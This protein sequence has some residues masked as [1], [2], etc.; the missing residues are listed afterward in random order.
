MAILSPR[1]ERKVSWRLRGRNKSETF[2][3]VTVTLQD[4]RKV[5]FRVQ[6]LTAPSK[7][8]FRFGMEPSG[9]NNFEGFIHGVKGSFKG[10]S[11]QV[12]KN[13]ITKWAKSPTN[14][15]SFPI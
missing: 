8:S 2:Y 5:P 6:L 4:G 13:K 14:R 3:T 9:G 1:N 15:L 12:V 10:R 7:Q 11:A